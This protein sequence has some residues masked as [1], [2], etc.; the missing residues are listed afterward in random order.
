[1]ELYGTLECQNPYSWNVVCQPAL[2]SFCNSWL[3]LA[4]GLAIPRYFVVQISKN[5]LNARPFKTITG[6]STLPSQGK[7]V[8]SSIGHD[9]RQCW[10]RCCTEG[11]LFLLKV[12]TVG[13]RKEW[14]GR[15]RWDLVI[16]I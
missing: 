9:F 4:L 12:E 6:P 2:K 3:S 11:L 13:I 10:C 7:F 14:H 8:Y 5:K 16:Y 15:E 1:M